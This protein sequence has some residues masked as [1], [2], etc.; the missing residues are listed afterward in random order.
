MGPEQ[1][2]PGCRRRSVL[3][4]FAPVGPVRLPVPERCALLA[5]ELRARGVLRSAH[6]RPR[7]QTWARPV[8]PGRRWSDPARSPR[9]AFLPRQASWQLCVHAA[10]PDFP[11]VVLALEW[12]AAG[13][14]AVLRLLAC[15]AVCLGA[16]PSTS[17]IFVRTCSLSSRLTS[18]SR[19]RSSSERTRSCSPRISDRSSATL[20]A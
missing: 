20:W 2:G 3:A 14:A 17:C 7:P 12:R 19:S 1:R 5:P 9:P 10:A 6:P 11:A 13:T 8:R 4:W 18:S 15:F 16:P